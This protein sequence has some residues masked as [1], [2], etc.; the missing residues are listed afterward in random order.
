ML[1][2]ASWH[3]WAAVGAMI[4]LIGF[5]AHQIGTRVPAVNRL[6]TASYGA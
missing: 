2:L 1:S 5:L 3:N 6:V 4:L